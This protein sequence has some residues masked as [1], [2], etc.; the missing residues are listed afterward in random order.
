MKK[1]VFL[2]LILALTA[3]FASAKSVKMESMSNVNNESTSANI[4]AKVLQDTELTKD[5]TVKKDTII[6][7]VIVEVIAPKRAKRNGYII[8]NPVSYT[9]NDKTISL[10]N[11]DIMAKV[12]YYTEPNYKKMAI[13]TG[14]G[15][16]ASFVKGGKYIVKFS[17]GVIRPEEGE[18][19]LK[20]GFDSL[21]QNS[22]I[23]YIGKGKDVDIKVGDKLTYKFYNVNNPKWKFWK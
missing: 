2:F 18:S 4:C 15:V 11:K 12:Q 5:I 7:G 1:I 10:T 21:Y 16:G 8:I 9:H 3:P 6:N 22:A 23:S 20:S 17:E 14:V 19:R 13:E